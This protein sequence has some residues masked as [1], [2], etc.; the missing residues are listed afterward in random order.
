MPISG[1][2]IYKK[3]PKTNCGDCKVPTCMAFAMKVAAGQAA[4]SG[5]PHIDKSLIEELGKAA[6]PPIK[7]VAIGA[8][9]RAFKI[10]GELV[11]F[12]H[13]KTF[14]NPC[15]IGG[16]ITDR[17]SDKE[18][19]EQIA[20][21]Q[22]LQYERIG[23]TLHANLLA[24][25]SD[26]PAKLAA[27]VKR[28]EANSKACIMLISENAD[29]LKAG[30]EAVKS[31]RPVICGANREN[32][33][34]VAGLAKS[35]G[36]PVV[37]RGRNLE[38]AAELTQKLEA[39]G[40]KDILI[41]SGARG[42]RQAL[43]DQVNIRR[44]AI[45]KSFRALGYPTVV[46]P[47][48]MTE[49]PVMEAVYASVLIAKYAGLVIL[50]KLRSESL[51]PLLVERLNLYTDPQ[52]PMAQTKGIYPIGNPSQNSPVLVTSN[53]SLTYFIVSGELETGRFP[54]WLMV[55]DT[56]GLSVLTAWAAGKFAADTI[57]PF[58]NK[59]GIEAKVKHRKII[60]PGLVASISGELQD[61]LAGWEVVVGPREASGIVPFL[62]EFWK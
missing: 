12:R 39:A 45:K 53:F 33:D 36:L 31:R 6:A 40:V 54:A 52:K 60:I 28:V 46:F 55:A 42:I 62:R 18:V 49:D 2:D 51:F 26:D 8:G 17:M 16:L 32:V 11:L 25:K 22:S 57:A 29:A 7:T 59:S 5:C 1:I 56:E 37:V 14:V 34:Q 9:E 35:S 47:C 23:L 27:L 3:L 44:A 38:D 4:I 61:E 48:E 41:D 13:E 58:V 21:I 19:G 50:G 10:G 20:A 43:Q 30:V 24:V 15:G